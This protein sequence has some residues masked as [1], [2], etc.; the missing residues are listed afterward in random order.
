MK[1]LKNYK[2]IKVHHI[3]FGYG[4]WFCSHVYFFKRGN[5]F[6]IIPIFFICRDCIYESNG[7]IVGHGDTASWSEAR[8]KENDKRRD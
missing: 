1:K 6:A 7:H 2:P 3:T 8:Q 4:Y 5:G